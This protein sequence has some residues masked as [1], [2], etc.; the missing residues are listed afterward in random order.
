M[1]LHH[2]LAAQRRQIEAMRAFTDTPPIDGA[3]DYS[4][5]TPEQYRAVRAWADERGSTDGTSKANP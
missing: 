3:R 4:K 2:T 5:I 1:S